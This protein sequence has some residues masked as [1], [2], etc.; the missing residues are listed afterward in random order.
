[1]PSKYVTALSQVL[2]WF[3][4]VFAGV[5]IGDSFLPCDLK[6]C[7]KNTDIDE[8]R[9]T[10]RLKMIF[11]NLR[12][13]FIA[14]IKKKA[15][16]ITFIDINEMPA[17]LLNFPPNLKKII[18]KIIP[19]KS[20]KKTSNFSNDSISGISILNCNKISLAYKYKKYTLKR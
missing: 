6:P 11:R 3:G 2:F 17:Y 15:P 20:T 8:C 16:N 10:N 9:F 5:V 7:N 4:V 14:L 13:Q 1:M 18:P 19:P 12:N